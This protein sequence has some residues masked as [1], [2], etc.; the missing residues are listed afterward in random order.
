MAE[1]PVLDRRE[2]TLR[3]ALALLGGV[4]ITISGCGG[5]SGSGPSSSNPVSPTGAQPDTVGAISD[6]HGHAAVITSAELAAGS[7]LVLDIRGIASH[8]HIV[9]LSAADLARIRSQQTVA[10]DSSTMGEHMHTVTFSR[11]GE[12]PGPDY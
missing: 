10:K 7:A 12:A 6:N 11:A 4:T 3:S 1:Y 2:F 9:E 5:G 8:P